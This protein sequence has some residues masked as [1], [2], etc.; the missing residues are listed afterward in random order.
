M[1]NETEG[2]IE[3]V[4]VEVARA[5]VERIEI[6]FT[7]QGHREPFG[8]HIDRGMTVG[9]FGALVARSRGIE[10]SVEVFIED[11]DEP[12]ETSMVL[13]DVV[14]IEGPPVHVARR[15]AKIAVTVEYN[16]RD[17]EREFRPNVTV[18]RIIVWAIGPDGFNLEGDPSDFQLKYE[19]EVLAPDTHLGQ[20]PHPHDAVKLDLVF[21]VKPQG[22]R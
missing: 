10:E 21:E 15:H 7:V 14:A 22:A 9:E 4:A 3:G 18:E 11:A 19:D 6:L 8:E 16:A 5:P 12:L 17:I 20:I 2:P 13:V 1:E